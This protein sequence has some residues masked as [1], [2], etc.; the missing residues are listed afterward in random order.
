MFAAKLGANCTLRDYAEKVTTMRTKHNPF[1]ER[2][3]ENSGLSRVYQSFLPDELQIDARAIC[4]ELENAGTWQDS[5]VAFAAFSKLV[6]QMHSPA[7]HAAAVIAA[8]AAATGR[9]PGGGGP[10]GKGGSRAG[11]GR[12]DRGRGRGRGGDRPASGAAAT[13]P[14]SAPWIPS[15]I[16]PN[17]EWCSSKTCH[18]NHGVTRPGH[19]CHRNS[20]VEIHL[21]KSMWGNKGHVEKLKN[22]RLS[23]HQF[24]GLSGQPKPV[25]GPKPGAQRAKT[26][27]HLG[28]PAD[29][30]DTGD[31][32]MGALSFMFDVGSPDVIDAQESMMDD[33]Y[34]TNLALEDN[35]ER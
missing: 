18:F 10:T 33:P 23:H 34:F 29:I 22:A 5:D 20:Q 19:P 15:C 3:Y 25:H 2:K 4:R 35:Y 14:N 21:P 1:L 17:D 11:G 24:F 7:A 28:L 16:L 8:A 9:T 30:D 12:K 6:K 31:A 32:S 27:A 26:D 13:P